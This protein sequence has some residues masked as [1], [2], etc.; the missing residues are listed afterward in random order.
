MSRGEVDDAAR[1]RHSAQERKA[2]RIGLGLGEVEEADPRRQQQHLH[3]Q[4]LGRR[5]EDD[6]VDAALEQADDGGRLRLALQADRRR[7]DVVRVEQLGHQV[8][9][10]AARRADVEAPAGELRQRGQRRRLQQPLGGVGAIEEPDRLVEEA[11]ERDQ[12]VGVGVAVVAARRPHLVG[13]SLHEGDVDVAAG[14][15]QEGEV[16]GGAGRLA[17]PDL[18][19]VLLQDLRVALAELGVGALVLAGREND[20]ARRRRIE[21]PVGEDEQADREEDERGRGRDQVADRQQGV[22]NLVAHGSIVPAAAQ[23]G[24][25]AIL[26]APCDSCSSKT[27]E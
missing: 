9:H 12:A 27:I 2:A 3:Q 1:Q 22:A 20:L 19:P 24:A 16:L 17:Q 15:A 14:L 7:V 13:A 5:G 11:A 18:D 6:R 10:A 26:L 21:Q 25:A 23:A 4:R 8:G